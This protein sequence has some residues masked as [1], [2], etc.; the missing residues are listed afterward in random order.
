MK[1]LLLAVFV[2]SGDV[3]VT[4]I[5]FADEEACAHAIKTISASGIVEFRGATCIEVDR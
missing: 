1:W 5:E 3:E 2:A 4:R